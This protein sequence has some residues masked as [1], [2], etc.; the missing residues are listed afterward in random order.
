MSNL[1]LRFPYLIYLSLASLLLGVLIAPLVRDIPHEGQMISYGAAHHA[2]GVGHL[3]GERTVS[4][5]GAPEVSLEAAR[6]PGG[7]WNLRVTTAN[8]S[9][10]PEAV[11]NAHVPNTGHAHLYVDGVKVARLYGA[12]F[13]L[14]DLAPDVREI[15][16]ALSTNDH[17][18]YVVNDARIE[19]R[20][21]VTSGADVQ[22]QS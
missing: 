14:P 19:A 15:V 21:V 20:L 10:T 2:P 3:H 22:P 4:P 9:F 7:G 16:V 1:S 6:D 11:N 18:Y 12:H 5:D 8:F 17:A 13:H